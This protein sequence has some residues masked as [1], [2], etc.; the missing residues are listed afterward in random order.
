MPKEDSKRVITFANTEDYISFR[1][2]WCGG[3]GLYNYIQE[4]IHVAATYIQVVCFLCRHHVYKK[5]GSMDVDL[6]E[7]GPRFE[8]KC[9]LP[10]RPL[11]RLIKPTVQVLRLGTQVSCIFSMLI[12]V[13]CL[14]GF[15]YIWVAGLPYYSLSWHALHNVYICVHGVWW[16]VHAHNRH[17]CSM[18]HPNPVAV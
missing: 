13:F 3:S 16:F 11:N 5:N 14:S 2:V 12:H 4:H 9:M 7:V 18:I 10:T 17:C 8:M 6:K 15:F 1:S